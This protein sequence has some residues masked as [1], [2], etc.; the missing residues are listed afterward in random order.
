LEMPIAGSER[1]PPY[2]SAPPLIEVERSRQPQDDT[3]LHG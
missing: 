3:L 2:H 1:S